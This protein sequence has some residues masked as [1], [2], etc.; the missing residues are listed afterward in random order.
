MSNPPPVSIRIVI[1]ED[2]P[3]VVEGLHAVLAVD[4]DLDVV[5][6]ARTVTEALEVVGQ[7]R[8]HIVLLDLT[9]GEENGLEVLRRLRQLHPEVRVVVLTIHHDPTVYEETMRAGAHGYVVKE[10]PQELVRQAIHAAHEGLVLS[11][12][13]L[14]E[15]LLKDL[16]APTEQPEVLTSRERQVLHGIVRGQTNREISSDLGLAVVTIKKYVQSILGK[17]G[18]TDRTQA[19]IV[20]LQRG[21]VR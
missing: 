14:F 4:G 21:L 5:G 10:A 18:A 20:A 8:P 11:M 1:V 19:A 16:P 7:H 9:L 13:E 6:H 15:R 17:L 3:L 12:P 2:H